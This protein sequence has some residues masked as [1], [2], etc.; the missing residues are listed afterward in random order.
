MSD[1]EKPYRRLR[2]AAVLITA[3]GVLMALLSYFATKKISEDPRAREAIASRQAS[4]S[5][6]GKPLIGTTILE[7]YADPAT[8]PEDDLTLMSRTLG[9][10]SLLVKGSDPLPLGANEDIADALRGKN[11]A[12]LRFLPDDSP[13]FDKQGRIID[14]WG[15]PIYFHAESREHL[16]IRSAGPDRQMWTWDDLH[17]RYD[18][19]FLNGETLL[20]PSLFTKETELDRK[21]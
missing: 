21:Q 3:T 10:F 16:D 1:E 6:A 12:H 20:S 4:Q 11:K 15:T 5:K 14:R 17:R 19:S 18:G 2:A 7:H 9:N 13:V 8:K